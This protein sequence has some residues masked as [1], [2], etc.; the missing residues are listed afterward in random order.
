VK[1]L[2][3]EGLERGRAE[4]MPENV[5]F[6]LPPE[7]VEAIASAPVARPGKRKERLQDEELPSFSSAAPQLRFGKIEDLTSHVAP[8]VMR[9]A[10]LVLASSMRT[11]TG[12]ANPKPTD[13]EADYVLLHVLLAR[14]IR[15]DS[16]KLRTGCSGIKTTT[17]LADYQAGPSNISASVKPTSD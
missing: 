12:A 2:A 6:G 10:T 8:A 16:E 9:R 14:A 15:S 5:R 4:V 13:L 11:A 7:I 1:Y 3:E 17:G